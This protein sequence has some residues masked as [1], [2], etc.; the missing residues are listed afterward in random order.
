MIKLKM[1][2]KWDGF[3]SDEKSNFGLALLSV[4]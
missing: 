3:F 2:R 1:D 4:I